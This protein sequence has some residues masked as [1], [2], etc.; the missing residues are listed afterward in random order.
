[1]TRNSNP[2]RY[3][4]AQ[5]VAYLHEQHGMPQEQIAKLLGLVSQS[6]VSRL[7][8]YAKSVGLLRTET[9]FVEDGLSEDRLEYLRGLKQ[10]ND[11]YDACRK[12]NAGGKYLRNIRVY[13]SGSEDP[14]DE[15][16]RQRLKTFSQM[17]IGRFQELLRDMRIVGVTWGVT[18]SHSTEALAI[19]PRTYT[20]LR[21]V[22]LCAEL[23]TSP[24]IQYS[25][26]QLADRLN[27]II[28]NRNAD[29]ISLAGIPAYVPDEY[30]EAEK[31]GLWRYIHS[32]ASYR[33]IFG[34]SETNNHDTPP[35]VNVMDTVLTSVGPIGDPLSHS[36]RDLV[37]VTALSKKRLASLVVS[38]IGGVLL[39]KPGLSPSDARQV[40]NLKEIWTGVKL[41]H[42]KAV[43]QRREATPG[44]VIFAIG[45]SKA[46]VVYE[47][48]K[49]GLVNELIIDH[50][51]E[52]HLRQRLS[53]T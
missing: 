2:D 8:Q 23:H 16:L 15:G 22:P 35:L 4:R 24:S 7:L 14:T 38:D 50:D 29:P 47:A 28:N 53:R 25:S 5:E 42:L 9:R 26:S 31:R 21:F 10:R 3:S 48:I 1:M 52:N 49:Q 6:D 40:E 20:D 37:N 36:N 46:D 18:L 44:V 30:E 33:K 32:S 45:K 39:P 19:F 41:H 11:L 12:L 51:L 34:S 43:A 27:A 13:D 17:A